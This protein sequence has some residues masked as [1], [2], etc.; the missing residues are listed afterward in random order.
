MCIQKLLSALCADLMSLILVT[1]AYIT[2]LPKITSKPIKYHVQSIFF[3]AVFMIKQSLFASCL[4]INVRR[5]LPKS[6]VIKHQP[7]NILE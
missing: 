4:Q 3:F 5:L 2:A 6:E 7:Q 1:F